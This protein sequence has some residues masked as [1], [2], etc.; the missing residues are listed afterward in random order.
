MAIVLVVA[1]LGIFGYARNLGPESAIRAFH[2]AVDR[3]SSKD[4]KQSVLSPFLESN[5][6]FVAKRVEKFLDMDA[7]WQRKGIITK[8][9]TSN[10][11]IIY[12]FPDETLISTTWTVKKIN[13]SW[14][15][16][17]D[18]TAALW[19]RFTIFE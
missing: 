18:Q 10:I 11:K 3:K 9:N 1:T 12:A 15:I 17:I 2:V 6:S 13:S 5:L 7:E 4:L 19:Q 8:G 16:D 14:K